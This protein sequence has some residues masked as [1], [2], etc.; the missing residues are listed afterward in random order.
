MIEAVKS[1]VAN[2]TGEGGLLRVRAVLALAITAVVLAMF[3]DEKAIPDALL[4][5]WS[6]VTALYFGSRIASGG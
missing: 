3:F 2:L 4:V 5:T 6:G 1:L